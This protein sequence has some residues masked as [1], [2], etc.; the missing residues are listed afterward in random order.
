[1]SITEVSR[2]LHKP[3]RYVNHCAYIDS[4]YLLSNLI[5]VKHGQ[6]VKYKCELTDLI[7]GNSKVICR[8]EELEV[9]GF[10]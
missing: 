3:V 1:M 4:K 9:I 5:V 10:D 6:A 2:N 7:T 8:P